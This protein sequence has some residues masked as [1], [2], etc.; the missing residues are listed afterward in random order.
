MIQPQLPGGAY[1]VDT[2]PINT[3]VVAMT[4][5]GKGQTYIEADID[6]KSRQ[7]TKNNIICN[8]PK[9]GVTCFILKRYKYAA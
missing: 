1:I 5:A 3:L 9:G 7:D 2:R 4:R 8:D 6:C